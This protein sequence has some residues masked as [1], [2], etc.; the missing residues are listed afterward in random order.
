MKIPSKN[1]NLEL[2][3]AE[4]N[5]AAE[6]KKFTSAFLK[7]QC[8]GV[9]KRDGRKFKAGNFE[10]RVGYEGVR[11]ID[12]Q[13][14]ESYKVHCQIYQP[15]GLSIPWYRIVVFKSENPDEPKWSVSDSKI[16]P[17]VK[18][19]LTKLKLVTKKDWP[20]T[21]FYGFYTSVYNRL[22]TEEKELEEEEIN[23]DKSNETEKDNDKTLATND[24]GDDGSNEIIS[25]KNFALDDNDST[26]SD[27]FLWI[28]VKNFGKVGPNRHNA[29]PL[30]DG[31][32]SQRMVLCKDDEGRKVL[33]LVNCQ[34]IIQQ[35]VDSEDSECGFMC[36][37]ED[38]ADF[39]EDSEVSVA[40]NTLLKKINCVGT[41]H[42]SGYEFFG[43]TKPDVVQTLQKMVD[44]TSSLA[45]PAAKKAES[46]QKKKKKDILENV[47]NILN[48]NAGPTKD[49][50]RKEYK[51]ARNKAIH[52]V[53]DAA[54][55]GDVK[56]KKFLMNLGETQH[57]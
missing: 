19:C 13:D 4:A 38:G 11:R 15:E 9:S 50:S 16:T 28:G 22:L 52:S 42:W 17:C 47:E 24:E 1:I 3:L 46:K 35:N 21:Q 5:M 27:K 37:L 53:V 7:I 41:K 57:M 48:R 14:G 6:L 12:V 32:Q 56:S 45:T 30:F 31:F 18:Q 40:V 26:C 51:D 23:S 20:G 49:L 25:F 34:V 8:F 43:F 29:V 36:S 39:I 55:F 54:S 10:A 33:K 44:E 2:S